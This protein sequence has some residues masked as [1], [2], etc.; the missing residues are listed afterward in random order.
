MTAV[1]GE[2]KCECGG[3]RGGDVERWGHGE[4][5]EGNLTFLPEG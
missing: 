4:D 5:G 3:W 2:S 1:C